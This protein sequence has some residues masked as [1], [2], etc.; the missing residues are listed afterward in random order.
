MNAG[1]QAG[2]SDISRCNEHCHE[3]TLQRTQTV[4]ALYNRSCHRNQ[5]LPCLL[6]PNRH[7]AYTM[8]G[9]V[10]MLPIINSYAPGSWETLRPCSSGSCFWPIL[11]PLRPCG[12]WGVM[13]HQRDELTPDRQL[14]VQQQ[15]SVVYYCD[16]QFMEESQLL[17][18]LYCTWL[19]ANK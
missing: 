9:L 15:G 11:L 7:C 12:F 16:V 19:I 8:T 18:I 3:I 1:L 17:P 2:T 14:G 5:R 10:K 13:R 6:A 4:H